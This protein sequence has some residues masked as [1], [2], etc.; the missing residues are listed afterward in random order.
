MDGA[1]AGCP[2]RC[3][4][5]CGQR[6]GAVSPEVEM[7]GLRISQE[8]EIVPGCAVRV[9]SPSDLD[10]ESPGPGIVVRNRLGWSKL[11]KTA[12]SGGMVVPGC[13]SR[14]ES[15]FSPLRSR[16]LG[17]E[18][19]VPH[20]VGGPPEIPRVLVRTR[21]GEAPLSGHTLENGAGHC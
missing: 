4:P 13:P 15:F 12:G 10:P 5:T 7:R 1:G 11:E 2:T 14:R 9:A 16:R 6:V 19:V 8:V 3:D 21:T 20:S 17:K 18:G